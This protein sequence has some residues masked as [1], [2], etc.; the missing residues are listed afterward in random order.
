MYSEHCP[1]LRRCPSPLGTHKGARSE[2]G[3]TPPHRAVEVLIEIGDD[4]FVAYD[5]A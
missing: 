2:H 5:R 4:I 3:W 1:D